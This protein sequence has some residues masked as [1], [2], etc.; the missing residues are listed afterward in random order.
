MPT[1]KRELL[2]L[3]CACCGQPTGDLYDGIC[4][5]CDAAGC[6][7]DDSHLDIP[8]EPYERWAGK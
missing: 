8:D 6:R 4:A 5:D 1:C 2:D 3:D 7:V